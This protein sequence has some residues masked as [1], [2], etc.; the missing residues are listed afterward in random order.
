MRPE[1]TIGQLIYEFMAI[2]MYDSKMGRISCLC[3]EG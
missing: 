2:N 1:K 3:S